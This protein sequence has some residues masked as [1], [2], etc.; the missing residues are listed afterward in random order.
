MVRTFKTATKR[1]KTVKTPTAILHTIFDTEAGRGYQSFVVPFQYARWFFFGN[2]LGKVGPGA[3][4]FA[5]ERPEGD[6]QP[7]TGIRELYE[8]TG[9]RCRSIKSLGMGSV[10]VN[11]LKTGIYTYLGT[12][13][14]KDPQFQPQEDIQV[15]L[16]TPEELK[17]RVASTIIKWVKD[18]EKVRF[19]EEYVTVNHQN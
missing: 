6:V 18:V 11:R 19:I 13:A 9:Y 10:L 17:E 15:V 16:S 8:E 1:Y 2:G 5:G 4:M 12:G 14:V 3:A 7:L